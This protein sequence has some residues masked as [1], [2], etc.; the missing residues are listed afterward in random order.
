MTNNP[1]DMFGDLFGAGGP[2]GTP[3][4]FGS[5]PTPGPKKKPAEKGP[6][7][8]WTAKIIDGEHYVP[9]SQVADMLENNNILPGMKKRLRDH[10]AAYKLKKSQEERNR[11]RESILDVETGLCNGEPGKLHPLCIVSKEA[12]VPHF[13]EVKKS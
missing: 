4:P 7:G 13:V 5:R 11:S 2:F 6:N 9:M 8:G 1:G 3:N 12:H 10:I